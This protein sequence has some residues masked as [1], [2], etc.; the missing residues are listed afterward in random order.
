[1]EPGQVIKQGDVIEA[2]KPGKAENREINRTTGVNRFKKSNRAREVN[3]TGR[4][5]GKAIETREAI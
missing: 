5:K 4:A 1:M 3:K 2:I